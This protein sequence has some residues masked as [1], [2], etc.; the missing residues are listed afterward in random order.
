MQMRRAMNLSPRV[1]KARFFTADFPAGFF[2]YPYD[3]DTTYYIRLFHFPQKTGQR[4]SPA[5]FVLQRPARGYVSDYRRT[6]FFR[7]FSGGALPVQPARVIG[8]GFPNAVIR[9]ENSL[10]TKIMNCPNELFILLGDDMPYSDLWR[11]LF[12]YQF[13][14]YGL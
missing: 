14:N 10:K 3:A 13:G 6:G 12:H 9:G 7:R 1:S 5:K 4:F 8:S 2:R 11:S